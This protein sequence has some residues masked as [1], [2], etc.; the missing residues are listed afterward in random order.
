MA[1]VSEWCGSDDVG[2]T[3]DDADIDFDSVMVTSAVTITV[4][5]ML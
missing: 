2:K 5:V 3:S 4:K 1:M